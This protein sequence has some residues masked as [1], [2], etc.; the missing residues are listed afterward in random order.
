MERVPR[1]TFVPE[2]LRDHAYDDR[3]LPLGYGQTISQPYIV[4][5]TCEALELEGDERVL[6]I[7]TGSGYAAAVLGELAAEVHT[8]ERIPELAGTARATLAAAGCANVQVHEGDGALG[9]AEFAPYDAVAVAAAGAEVPS[10]VWGQLR[11]GGRIAL[12]LRTGRRSQA[13]C[14]FERA[15]GGP[16]LLASVAASFVPLIRNES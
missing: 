5:L 12:P 9:L 8:I 16:R 10:A 13:L 14:V 3:P 1:E 6:D 2:E 15:P 4:A 11:Q 7:G